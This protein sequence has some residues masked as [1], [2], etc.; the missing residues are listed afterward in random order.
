MARQCDSKLVGTIRNLILYNHLG[1]YRMRLKPQSVRRTPASIKSGLNF[2]KASRLSRQIRTLIA[3]I[4]PSNSDS[5]STN[6]FTGALNKFINWNEKQ[7]TDSP[8]LQRE[9]PF[10]TG[11]QF[12]SQAKLTSINAIQVAVN[13]TE[14]GLPEFRFV[15]FIPSETLHAS[16]YTDHIL[17]KIIFIS[18]NFTDLT[19]EKI[20]T[21]EIKI[22]YNSEIFH[23]PV[24]PMPPTVTSGKLIMMVMS[25]QYMVNRKNVIEMLKDIKKLPCGIVWAGWV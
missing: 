4:N 20:G 8:I 15:P 14:S 18:V 13:P 16:F 19:T 2:G 7:D 5:R 11:S 21:A 10:I 24:I 25:V 22:L 17:F 3:P 1:D 6:L 23:P 12:N 9:L